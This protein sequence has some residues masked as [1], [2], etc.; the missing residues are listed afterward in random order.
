MPSQHSCNCKK[1][2]SLQDITEAM[3]TIDSIYS[4][5]APE[6]TYTSIELERPVSV[7][8]KIDGLEGVD[9]YH[10][11]DKSSPEDIFI[12]LTIGV[13]ALVASLYLIWRMTL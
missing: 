13:L 8:M 12:K 9:M 3:K 1:D 6:R 5:P 11:H 10:H 7:D 4:K 2:I